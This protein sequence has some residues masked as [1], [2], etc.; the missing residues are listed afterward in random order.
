MKRLVFIRAVIRRARVA[1]GT[2]TQVDDRER[3]LRQVRLT[4]GKHT[5]T[6]FV[7]DSSGNQTTLTETVTV[8]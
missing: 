5:L 7:I 6:Y 3:D 8:R 2:T 4:R 1:S